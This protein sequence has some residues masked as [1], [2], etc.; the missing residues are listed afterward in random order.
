[1]LPHNGRVT[2][3]TGLILYDRFSVYN[4]YDTAPYIKYIYHL[5]YV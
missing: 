1:M 2:F 5:I 3:V 4:W